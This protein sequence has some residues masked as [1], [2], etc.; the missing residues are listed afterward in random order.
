VKLNDRELA[1]VLAALRLFQSR[2][3]NMPHFEDVTPLDTGE[4]DSLCERINCNGDGQA[5][6][7]KMAFLVVQEGGSSTEM[8]VTGHATLKKA[9]AHRRSCARASYRTSP[10]VEVP[11]SLVKTQDFLDSVLRLM[12]AGLR[13]EYAK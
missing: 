7:A 2:P 9:Q 4:I 11:E 1:T 3:C 10:P 12:Q 8:Y 6:T 13:C 5:T